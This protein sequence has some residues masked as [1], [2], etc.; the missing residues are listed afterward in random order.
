V[1]VA[2]LAAA[3]RLV[4]AELDRFLRWQHARASRAGCPARREAA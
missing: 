4:D 3:E 1:D 2:A